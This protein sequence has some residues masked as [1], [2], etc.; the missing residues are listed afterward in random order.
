[1]ANERRVAIVW[2]PSAERD[3]GRIHEFLRADSPRRAARMA[4]RV[5]DAVEMLEL[6][7][8]LG[9]VADDVEPIGRCRHLVVA[10][11]RV[12]YQVADRQVRILRMTNL[13]ALSKMIAQN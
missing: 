9:E 3:L 6:Q 10:P 1:M 12:I 4:A 7:P 2:A 13:F 5:L 8:E 11:L